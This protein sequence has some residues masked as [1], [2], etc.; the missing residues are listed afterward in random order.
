[1]IAF[2]S[3]ASIKNMNVLEV[4]MKTDSKDLNFVDLPLNV[5]TDSIPSTNLCYC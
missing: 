1:M 5:K 3:I 2:K 4:K